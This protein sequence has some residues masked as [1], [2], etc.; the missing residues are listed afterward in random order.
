VLVLTV[1]HDEVIRIGPDI[2]VT[3]CRAPS[4]RLRLG[5]TAPQQVEIWRARWPQ[6]P[7]LPTATADG[8]APH[9]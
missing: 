8:D 1:K 9:A 7:Q 4:G 5:I 3:I 2:A 6:P